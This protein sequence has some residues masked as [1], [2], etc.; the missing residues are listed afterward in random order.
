[1]PRPTPIESLSSGAPIPCRRHSPGGS[2][3]AANTSG[4]LSCRLAEASRQS[5][6]FHGPWP[7]LL[8]SKSATLCQTRHR[9]AG[10][11]RRK[12]MRLRESQR[13]ASPPG[14]APVRKAAPRRRDG[15]WARPACIP[16]GMVARNHFVQAALPQHGVL[17]H[18]KQ[19]PAGRTPPYPQRPSSP[20]GWRQAA[21]PSRDGR[22]CASLSLFCRLV[23]EAAVPTP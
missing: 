21:A 7:R 15:V 17:H 5:A 1:M 10:G 18:R 2:F 19:N 11:F 13:R 14:T 12:T 23:R 4:S 3:P 8:P 16:P 6:S 20:G 9:C 22:P